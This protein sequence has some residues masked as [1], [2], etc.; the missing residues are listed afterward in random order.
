VTTSNVTVERLCPP[1]D[2]LF[3]PIVKLINTSAALEFKGCGV[4]QV[5]A[6]TPTGQGV[7][8]AQITS[9]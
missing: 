6:N 2:K 4:S 5:L 7:I 9:I 1:I 8:A 3:N